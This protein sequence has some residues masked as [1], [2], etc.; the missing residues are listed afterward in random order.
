MPAGKTYTREEFEEAVLFRTGPEVI[1]A[2]GKPVKTATSGGDDVWTYED[3][4]RDAVTGKVDR[5]TRVT[6]RGKLAQH[7]SSD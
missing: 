1:A 5:T 4:V 3:L 7:I 2:V 6:F